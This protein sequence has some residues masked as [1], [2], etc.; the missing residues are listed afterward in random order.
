MTPDDFRSAMRQIPAAVTVV[1]SSARG[2]CHGLTVTAVA[3]VSVDPPQV[4]VCVNRATRSSAAISAAGRFGLNYLGAE[5]IE[6]AE[7]F[8]APTGDPED[9][10]RRTRW[11]ANP[12]GTPLLLDA[13]VA[14]ECVVVN[15]IHSGTHAIFIGQVI[16]VRCRKGHALTYQR[17]AFSRPNLAPGPT[18]PKP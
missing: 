11:N 14:F 18:L 16:D 2:V 3:S 5:H 12:S 8:A 13:L 10:F 1:T 6:L 4:L 17:G 7:V 15:E 9:R